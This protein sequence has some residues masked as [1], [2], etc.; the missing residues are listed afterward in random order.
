VTLKQVVRDA[1]GKLL[2]TRGKAQI[3]EICDECSAAIWPGDDMVVYDDIAH[4]GVRGGAPTHF[5]RHYCGACG[6]LLE[7]SLTTTE[8]V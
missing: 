2:F 3:A 5:K 4:D 8:T 7:D 6:Q 1:E